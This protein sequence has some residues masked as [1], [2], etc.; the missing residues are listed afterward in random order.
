MTY[1]VEG[2]GS[3]KLVR[4]NVDCLEDGHRVWLRCPTCW[5]PVHYL[6]AGRK[7]TMQEDNSNGN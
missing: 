5:K 1:E 4:V 2:K 6:E 3:F 7:H